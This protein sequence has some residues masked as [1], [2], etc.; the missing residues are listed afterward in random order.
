MITSKMSLRNMLN[1]PKNTTT[2]LRR[3]KKERRR[4]KKF[5]VNKVEQMN[6]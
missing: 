4:T 6:L 5:K 1:E 3:K 2:P